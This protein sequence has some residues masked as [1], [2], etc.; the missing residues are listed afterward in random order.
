MG[1][2]WANAPELGERMAAKK[3]PEPGTRQGIET[4]IAADGTVSYRVRVRIKGHP[5]VSSTHTTIGAAK[6]W[7][8]KTR[9]EI[10]ERRHF[11]TS[12]SDRRRTV[13]EIIE[14]YKRDELPLLGKTHQKLREGRLDWWIERIG[15]YAGV[16][17]TPAVLIRELRA[18]EAGDGER[19]L[20]ARTVNLYHSDIRRVFSCAVGWEWL[21]SNPATG[22]RGNGGRGVKK[23]REKKRRVRFLSP[24]ERTRL[25]EACEQEDPKHL[26]PLVVLCLTTGGR[27]GEALALR[28]RNIDFDAGRVYYEET[29]NEDARS[30][31]LGK[32]AIAALKRRFK[33]RAINPEAPVF[34][35]Y[36]E[37]AWRRAR[38][39]AQLDSP[40]RFH[41]L[42][43]TFCSYLAMNGA[44]LVQLQEAAGHRS[45]Q[46][47]QI[48]AHL[49]PTHADALVEQ[50]ADEI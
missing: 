3:R 46:A 45:L 16:D 28:R 31:K 43:H 5:V 26:Y 17:I 40:F 32:L 19:R 35:Y 20:S 47:V 4:R 34:P 6:S 50:I 27:R 23:R 13:K 41:D 15:A 39:A 38:R 12:A 37:H 11:G 9:T 10:R 30:V 21:A 8:E 49:M 2:W 18:K 29:K 33:V 1:H 22:P 42:R 25:L 36:N 48:Y 7:Q 24:D 14:R 44:S